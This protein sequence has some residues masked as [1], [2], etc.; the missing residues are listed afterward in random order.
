MVTSG[1]SGGFGETEVGVGAMNGG[2]EENVPSV[3]KGGGA[4]M[5]GK[6]ASSMEPLRGKENE[7]EDVDVDEDDHHGEG[8]GC[9]VG[10][11]DKILGVTQEVSRLFVLFLPSGVLIGSW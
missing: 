6:G 3:G 7:H 11:G 2:E 10:L 4:R 8:K 5:V 9:K 1:R